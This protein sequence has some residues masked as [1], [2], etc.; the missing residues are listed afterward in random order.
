MS[1]EQDRILQM[2]EAGTITAS[3]ANEL[4]AAM[5]NSPQPVEASPAGDRPEFSRPWEVPLF[6]GM[7]VAA[8]GAMG[9]GRLYLSRGKRSV[10]ARTGAWLTVLLGLTAVLVGLWSRNAP[11]LHLHVQERD[12]DNVNISL[13]LPLFLAEWVIRF[14]RDYLDDDASAHMQSVAAFVEALRRGDKT[15]PLTIEVDEGEG[16]RVLIYIG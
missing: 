7:V 12:G 10:V 15:E 3:E 5:E 1:E 14:S 13:P 6:G 11:W 2:V 9:M 8:L 4:L 16:D